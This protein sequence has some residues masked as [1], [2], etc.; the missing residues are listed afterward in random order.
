M[1]AEEWGIGEMGLSPEAFWRLTVREFWIKW[2]A[3]QRA[4]DWER[5]LLFEFVL[6]TTPGLSQKTETDL[7]RS[8]H[9][10]RRYPI[11]RWLLHEAPPP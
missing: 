6:K 2:R 4:R 3:H 10:L 1:W 11:K 9:Q 5:S 7:Q 8:I